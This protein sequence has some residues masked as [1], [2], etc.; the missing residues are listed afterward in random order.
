MLVVYVNESVCL[1]IDIINCCAQLL[2][3]C[4]T[5]FVTCDCTALAVIR[6]VFFVQQFCSLWQ[7][8]IGFTQYRGTSILY[9]YNT[10]G[11]TLNITLDEEDG[12]ELAFVEM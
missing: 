11:Y 3:N 10:R 12:T 1:N 6:C 8:I 4:Q 5:A 9:G 2:S 7:H